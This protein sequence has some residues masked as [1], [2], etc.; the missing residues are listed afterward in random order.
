MIAL[1]GA[2]KEE[3]S[4]LKGKMAISKTSFYQDCILYEGKCRNQASLLVLTGVGKERAQKAV[5]LALEK[6]PVTALIS[7]G[8]GG[9]LNDKTKTG[10]IVVC[11]KLICEEEHLGELSVNRNVESDSLLTSAC[12]KSLNET[13]LRFIVGNGITIPLVSQTP[14]TK[15]EL[16]KKF[17]ADMVDM[18]SYWIG[19]RAIENKL[20]FVAVR[21][22]FD[23]LED[24]LSPLTKVVSSE[25]KIKFAAFFSSVISHPGRISNMIYY[26]G[27]ARKARRNLTIFL[28]R[29][30]EEI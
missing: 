14:E 17:T 10:D 22:I 13:G 6:Y 19:Q 2:L 4:E 3:L 16:G 1:F 9:A 8:F 29:F 25:G 5:E 15:S 27:N 7:T 11:S 23:S 30:L 20:P 26:A 21:S 12:V 18:E 24:D 28:D